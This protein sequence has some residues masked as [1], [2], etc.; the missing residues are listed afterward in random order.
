LYQE[1]RHSTV[2]HVAESKGVSEDTVRRALVERSE[3]EGEEQEPVKHLTMDEFSVRKGQ[4]YETAFHD[5]ERGRLARLE[6]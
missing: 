6:L 1:A 5:W 4:R 3:G 2:K